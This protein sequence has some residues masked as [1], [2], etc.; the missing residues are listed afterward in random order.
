M[1]V[2]FTKLFI[3]GEWR[4]ASTGSTFEVRNPASKVVVGTAASASAQDCQDAAEAA[5]RAL[6]A[7]ENTSHSDRR[8]ML[9]RAS[10]IIVSKQYQ[11]K[12]KEALEEETCAPDYMFVINMRGAMNNL[13]VAAGHQGALKGDVF[14]SVMPGAQ[15][16]AQ[17]R[18][19]GVVFAMAPWNAPVALTMRAIAFPLLCGNTIVLKASELSPRT[20]AICV[21]SFAEAGIP[22]GVLNLIITSREDAPARTSEIIGHPAVRK[23]NFTGSDVVGRIIAMEAAKYLKPVV[24]ELGGKAPAVVLADA[25]I[26]KAARGITSGALQHAGQIC[27]STERVIILRPVADAL[28]AELTRLFERVQ[29]NDG[30]TADYNTLFSEGLA[31]NVLAMIS[32]ARAGGAK[33]LVG[34]LKRDGAR[35]R[36]HIIADAKPGMR[37]WDR[38][39]FGPVIVVSVVDSIDEAVDLANASDYSL[40]A[41]LWTQDINLAF[42]V[43]PRIRAGCTSINGPTFATEYSRSHQGLTGSSGY[44]AFNVDEW[45]HVRMI[46]IH[47][48]NPPPYPISG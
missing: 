13:R 23:I 41:S 27:M 35:M 48:R 34:D 21:E 45:S 26:G 7:W 1:S 44:G 25:D 15:V 30:P 46:V 5:Q 29:V 14:P 20:Q 17:R 12:I 47:P 42:E 19:I 8:D 32:E 37:L 2:P 24:L 4:S 33:V 11:G 40:V 6:A 18:A 39:S 38:E 3:D 16:V 9:L 22:A 28:I 10:D 36:P 31:E 43:A